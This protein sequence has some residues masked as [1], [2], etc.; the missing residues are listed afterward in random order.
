MSFFIFPRTTNMVLNHRDIIEREVSPG[1]E[2]DAI[3]DATNNLNTEGWNYQQLLGF[4]RIARNEI[5]NMNPVERA[6]WV[7]GIAAGASY[8]IFNGMSP[9]QIVETAAQTA[10]T[11]R[12]IANSY[13]Y[14][15]GVTPEQAPNIN[16]L[17]SNTEQLAQQGRQTIRDMSTTTLARHTRWDDNGNQ[18]TTTPGGGTHTRFAGKSFRNLPWRPHKQLKNRKQITI[19][20][21]LC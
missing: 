16:E 1:T 20:Q 15:P 9:A 7:S 18:I 8:G 10:S 13:G 11:T 4:I 2:R 21:N 6:A 19:L 5:A 14:S 12:G 17:A 3:L